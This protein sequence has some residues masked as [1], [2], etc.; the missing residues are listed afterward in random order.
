[1]TVRQK[2]IRVPVNMGFSQGKSPAPAAA[3]LPARAACRAPAPAYAA[4]GRHAVLLPPLM[5]RASAAAGA[6]LGG[7]RLQM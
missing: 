5:R 2:E 6:G 7:F 3:R 4:L 1:M